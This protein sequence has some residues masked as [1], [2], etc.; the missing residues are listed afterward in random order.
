MAKNCIF[1]IAADLHDIGARGNSLQFFAHRN[2]LAL[3]QRRESKPVPAEIVGL[4]RAHIYQRQ[5]TA[6]RARPS[7][8][9]HLGQVAANRAAPDECNP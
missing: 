4:H 7:L 5:L 8:H 1:G 3:E 2:G 9:Q 6:G